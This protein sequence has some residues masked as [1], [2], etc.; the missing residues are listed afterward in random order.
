MKEIVLLTALNYFS[1]YFLA[2]VQMRIFIVDHKV[3]V[4]NSWYI[5]T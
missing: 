2:Y 3:Y 1:L 5:S 4:Y